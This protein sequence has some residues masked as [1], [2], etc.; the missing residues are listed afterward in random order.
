MSQ[1]Y[2]AILTAIGEAKLANAAALNTTLKLSKMAVGDGGGITPTP[3][4]SQTQLVGEWY[5]AGL[6]SLVIDPTNTSQIIAELVIPEATGG[7]WIREMGLFDADNNLIAVANCP[8]SYKPQLAE[9]SGRTQILRMVL[10]VSSTSAVELK[11]DPTVVLA[12]RGYVDDAITTAINKLD[13]KQ[14]VRVA[15][16]A[17]I[18][19]SGLQTIDGIALAIGD[20]VLVKNQSNAIQNGLYV[21]ASGTWSRATDADASLEVTSELIVAVEEGTVNK[22][23]IWHLVT[24]GPIILGTTPLAFEQIYTA[25]QVKALL[26]QKAPLDSP[27]FVNTPKAPTAPVGTNTLQLATT[28]FVQTAIAALING[29]P[30]SMDALNELA[31]AMGND[32]NFSATVLNQLA[33]KAPLASPALTG[34]PTAPTPATGDNDTS[35]ATTAFVQLAM[36]VFGLGSTQ[37][38]TAENIDT[39]TTTGFCRIVN[40]TTLGTLPAPGFSASLLSLRFSNTYAAQLAFIASTSDGY[41]NRFFWRTNNANVW[42]PWSEVPALSS[43]AAVASSGS[44]N[45]LIDLQNHWLSGSSSWKVFTLQNKQASGSLSLEYAN[46]NGITV[47]S[48]QGVNDGAGGWGASFYYTPPGDAAI[49]RRTKWLGVGSDGQ[50]DIAGRTQIRQGG[51]L[52]DAT[53][54]V[55][56]VKGDAN[57]GTQG[58]TINNYAPTISLIDRSA[59]V[60]SARWRVDGGALALDFDNTDQGTTWNSP[61]LNI[62]NNGEIR[63]L[64]SNN[65]RIIS[66]DYG[67]FWRNDGKALYLMITNSGDQYGQWNNLRPFAMNLVTGKIDMSCG[68]ATVTPVDGDSSQNAANTAWVNKAI[69]SRNARFT[70]NGTFTVPAGITTLYLSGC[71][72]GAGGSGGAGYSSSGSGGGSG[73]GAA[74][75][76]IKTAVTVTPGATY[77]VTVGGAGAGGA[78]GASQAAGGRGMAG[79][80]TVFAKSDGT[81]LLTLTGGAAGNSGSVSYGAGGRSN[82]YGSTDGGDGIPGAAGGGNGGG[83]GS[84]PFGTAGGGGRAGDQGGGNG[85][86]SY[87]YGC[88]GGGGG[89]AYLSG[90][91]GAGSAGGQGLLIIEW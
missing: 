56:L 85:T 35:I 36:Q 89:G 25:V 50:I 62:N 64:Y 20:R 66:G 29:A 52:T 2:Y 55:L 77:T 30:G 88:G 59:G 87:G 37:I 45:D 32:P 54:A 5:R 11:I 71:G 9:G 16:A 63:A 43:L 17:N 10:I 72:G 23:S 82:G 60:K 26:D 84:S 46:A 18:T 8:P 13:N 22:D 39:L 53:G 48:Y 3:I 34:N 49:N 90:K 15:T 6:N 81:V 79:G 27:T 74:Q 69:N 14:S 86:A 31:A 58:L 67:T 75:S 19:L 83:G 80:D 78:S 24:N 61:V 42:T 68:L 65:Y 47:M 28:A 70:A 4:R 1:T 7:A 38:P 40:G 91:G 33:Q 51:A 76:A 12:T 41:R 44:L 73:G 57:D 21:A